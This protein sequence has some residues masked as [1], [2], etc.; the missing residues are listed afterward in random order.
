MNKQNKLKEFVLLLLGIFLLLIII[1]YLRVVKICCLLFKIMIPVFIGFIYAW[2]MNPLIELLSSK[3]EKRN[4]MSILV[5][6]IILILLGIF[7]YYLIPTIY[8]E[9]SELVDKIPIVIEMIK[10][11][12]RR[13]GLNI[14]TDQIEKYLITSVP[15]I[16]VGMLK[17][18]FKYIGI[19]I[20]GLFLGLYMSMDY[21]RMICCIQGLIPKRI[22]K[23]FKE[24][25]SLISKEVRKC[26][27]GTL[28]IS[29]C[30]FIMS[31][32]VFSFLKLDMALLLGLICGI[33][34]LIPYIGP[35][36]GGIIAVLVAFSKGKF[37]GILTIIMCF[38]IQGIENYILQP[39]VMSKSVKISPI[40]IMI[41]LL[42]FGNLFG[43]VG[44][45]MAT[46]FV[47]I[48][49]VLVEYFYPKIRECS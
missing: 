10:K 28:L 18:C 16:L 26:I 31:F 40:L 39:M 29:F 2:L 49:K 14:K 38:V 21:E 41:G 33:T 11:K 47:A 25:T 19:I 30:L 8:R 12:I 36:I 15:L 20:V 45:I 17:G 7:L 6:V 5:F 27:N 44:M 46:P 43:V 9:V 23:Q 35:Y 13:L 4:K 3:K 42:V 48:I 37:I 32:L 34:D 24:I 1:K 22:E